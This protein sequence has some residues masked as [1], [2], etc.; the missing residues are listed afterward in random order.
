MCHK[1]QQLPIYLQ[2]YSL[3]LQ[4]LQ[5]NEC[6]SYLGLQF[7]P[8]ILA[9]QSQLELHIPEG[10]RKI[11]IHKTQVKVTSYEANPFNQKKYF[12]SQSIDVSVMYLIV[13]LKKNQ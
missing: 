7:S 11:H 10:F 6:Q 12:F 9:A 13:L 2:L 3:H 5:L 1:I 8:T 4:I